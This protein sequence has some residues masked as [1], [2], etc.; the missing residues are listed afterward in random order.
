MKSNSSKGSLG[1]SGKSQYIVEFSGFATFLV[2]FE[3]TAG[4]TERQ[5]ISKALKLAN[6]PFDNGGGFTTEFSR[7]ECTYAMIANGYDPATANI[8]GKPLPERPRLKLVKG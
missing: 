4:L 5:I 7:G 3:D 8:T 1:H 2:D 6:G